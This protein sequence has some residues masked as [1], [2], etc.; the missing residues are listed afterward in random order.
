MA[1][2]DKPPL[3]TA[4]SKDKPK[5]NHLRCSGQGVVSCVS[6]GGASAPHPREHRDNGTDGGKALSVHLANCVE[7]TFLACLPLTEK[8]KTIF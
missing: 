7:K 8:P 6:F 1:I 4:K 5:R 2:E 3:T